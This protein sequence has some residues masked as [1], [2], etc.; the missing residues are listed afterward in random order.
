MLRLEDRQ[1]LGVVVGTSILVI[2]GRSDDTTLAFWKGSERL[3]SLRQ[4]RPEDDSIEP[5][6]VGG[7]DASS[8][9][10]IL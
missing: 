4:E 1:I 6:T 7:V 3:P 5:L 2:L 9:P 8:E 10:I